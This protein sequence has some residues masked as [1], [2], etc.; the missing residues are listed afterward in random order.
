MMV[1]Q[2]YSWQVES[3]QP[4]VLGVDEPPVTWLDSLNG[5]A[6][7]NMMPGVSIQ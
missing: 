1:R 6:K 4:R 7:I 5:Y 2:G 3:G